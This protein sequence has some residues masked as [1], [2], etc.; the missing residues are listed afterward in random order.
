VSRYFPLFIPIFGLGSIQIDSEIILQHLYDRY[1]FVN[2]RSDSSDSLK[3]MYY[4]DGQHDICV[5]FMTD[6]ES[7]IYELNRKKEMMPL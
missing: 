5:D 6:L 3:E 4:Y 2:E 7:Y 1:T